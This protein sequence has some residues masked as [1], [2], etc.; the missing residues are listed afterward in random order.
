MT[1]FGNL[2][3]EGKETMTKFWKHRPG[4][5]SDRLKKALGMTPRYKVI[6]PTGAKVYDRIETESSDDKT[7]TTIGEQNVEWKE[8]TTLK[9]GTIVVWDKQVGKRIKI[10][11]PI[12][13]WLWLTTTE[14]E[15]ILK[16]E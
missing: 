4:F 9:Y 1:E 3:F 11:A 15:E 5:I 7:S 10:N 6:S 12:N 2:Y 8:T 13:G 14:N 16:K